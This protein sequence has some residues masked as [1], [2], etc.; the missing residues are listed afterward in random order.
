MKLDT[1]RALFVIEKGL[2]DRGC[3]KTTTA[4]SNVC[5][6]LLLGNQY[7]Y[8]KIK[9]MAD[10]YW[11]MP[12]LIDL[13]GDKDYKE[14]GLEILSVSK[15]KN[16]IKTTLGTI[17]FFSG[18]STSLLGLELEEEQFLLGREGLVVDL[19]DY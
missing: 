17:T 2:R 3:G 4:L 5:N 8:C 15:A 1:E 11:L 13:I 14:D 19:I 6:H 7:I 12:M 18:K 10:L 16:Q 9:K